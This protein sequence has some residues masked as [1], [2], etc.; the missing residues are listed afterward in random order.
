M[1][2]TCACEG[3]QLFQGISDKYYTTIVQLFISPICFFV[4]VWVK[5]YFLAFPYQNISVPYLNILTS[6]LPQSSLP[7]IVSAS[8]AS[9]HA[10]KSKLHIKNTPMSAQYFASYIVE[11]GW[12][13]FWAVRLIDMIWLPWNQDNTID[14]YWF[15]KLIS[16][17]DFQLADNIVGN[18]E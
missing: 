1:I 12:W 9:D 18:N 13:K 14:C 17:N 8:V 5:T 4:I 11:S 6:S 3:T 15:W 2:R 7:S 16:N 10:S